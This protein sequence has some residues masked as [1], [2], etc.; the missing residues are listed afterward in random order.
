MSKKLFPLR[1]VN[2]DVGVWQ[3]VSLDVRGLRVV[4]LDVL[5]IFRGCVVRLDVKVKMPLNRLTNMPE[6]C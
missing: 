4:D 6:I 2:L 1:E 5:E 3:V